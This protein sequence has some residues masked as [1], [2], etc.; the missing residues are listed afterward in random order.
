MRVLII[1]DDSDL[2]ANLYDY[3]EAKG[4]SVDAAGDGVTGLHLAITQDY[5]V[6]VMDINM[7]GM[8]GMTACRKLR[9]EAGKQTPVLMLTARDTLDD[10]LAGFDSGA[11]DYLVKPFALQEL[12]ARLTALGKRGTSEVATGQQELQVA[13]LSFNLKTLE[14]KRA[15]QDISLTPTCLKILQL[16][17]SNSPN[18]VTRRQIEEALWRDSPPDSDSLRAHMHTLR[19]A[20]D[21]PFEQRL[22]Q[23]IHGIGFKLV[24]PSEAENEV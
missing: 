23:T 5:D 4:N 3:L 8:D 18:V 13:D 12:L 11:D 21:R 16:L 17:M 20:V 9:Q 6:I 10:K 15:G 19:N 2:A 1:E 14:V 22:I 7:P 24:P